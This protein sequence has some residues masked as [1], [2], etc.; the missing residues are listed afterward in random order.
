MQSIVWQI[1]ARLHQVS[2]G[3]REGGSG[4]AD[5]AFAEL[6]PDEIG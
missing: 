2:S 1:E 6:L 5:E 3:E 4:K